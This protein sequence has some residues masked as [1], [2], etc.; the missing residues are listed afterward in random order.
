MSTK[1]KINHFTNE[2]GNQCGS[3]NAHIISE[4]SMSSK[5]ISHGKHDC[6]VELFRH[7]DGSAAVEWD[8]EDFDTVQIGLELDGNIITGYDGV[9]EIPEPVQTFLQEIG[10]DISEL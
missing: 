7:D 1:I 9:F 10:F 5:P 2:S 4:T 3:F 6:T 8:I